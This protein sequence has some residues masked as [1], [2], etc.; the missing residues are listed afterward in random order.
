MIVQE[1]ANKTGVRPHVIRYYSRIGL[2]NPVRNPENGYQHFGERDLERLRFIRLARKV[3]YTLKNIKEILAALDRGEVSDIWIR[4]TL[5]QRLRIIRQERWE[6]TRLER[7][8]EETL[9]QSSEM[10]LRTTDIKGL[11]HWLQSALS[12]V[13]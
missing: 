11:V 4:D 2:L 3:G 9:S 1:L 8:I 12:S 10:P 13:I 5:E 7:F 6:L